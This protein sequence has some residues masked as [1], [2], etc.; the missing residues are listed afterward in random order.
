MRAGVHSGRVFTGDF[1]PPYRRTY[2]VLGDAI[3]TAARVMAARRAG[4]ILATDVV[5]SVRGRRSRRRRSS[6]SQRKGK[7]EPVTCLA[8][9]SD[10]RPARGA[11][12]DTPFVGR[13]HELDAPPCVLR[14]RRGGNA[15]D[16]RDRRASR[17]SASRASFEEA[18]AARARASASSASLRGVRGLDRRTT[19]SASRC[20]T[21]SASPPAAA[22]ADSEQRSAR[23]RRR[24]RPGARPVAAAARHP[25][26]ARSAADAGDA[27]DRR[28]L[29]PRDPR[30]RHL[31]LP[32]CDARRQPFA[33]VVEDAQFIDDSSADLLHRLSEGGRVAAV[34]ARHRPDTPGGLWADIDDDDVRSL[35]FDLLPLSERE[36]RSSS[37]SRPTSSRSGR[38]R[39]RSSRGAPAA[40][41]SSSSSCSTSRARPG[42][43]TL[44][45]SVEAV[46]T[47]DIDRLSPSDRI[48]LR[49]ASVLGVAFDEDL[50]DA[51]L[52]DE[53]TPATSLG[54]ARGLVDRHRGRAASLPQHTRPRRR[55]RGPAVPPPARAARPLCGGDRGVCRFGGG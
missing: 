42:R 41:R 37:R 31:P 47:A 20:A 38:T 46:V 25:A 50:L 13:E 12:R 7:A 3:N 44:P 4:E 9:R 27:G 24:R 54:R 36:L 53:V 34:R 39:S 14:R 35:V 30:R 2:A 49:Y 28:A 16:R 11:D 43:P 21:C 52:G 22:P 33:L 48:V 32:R 51:A 5:L 8:R 15:L 19:R 6:R 26:R 17:V 10:H 55:L 40:A 29:P 23:R 45:D 1:G 18:L